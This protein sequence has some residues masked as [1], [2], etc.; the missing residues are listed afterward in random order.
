MRWPSAFVSLL[1]RFAH[2]VTEVEH[3]DMSEALCAWTP[4]YLNFGL[5]RSFDFTNPTWQE[6]L[7]AYRT[8][9]DPEEWT[10]SF[11]LAHAREYPES[12]F[13]CFSYHYE[14]EARS[15]RFHFGNRDSSGRGPFREE[16]R[17]ERLRELTSMF[18]DVRRH[19]PE[20][21]FVRGRSWMYNVLPY[22]HLFPEEYI[23]TATPVEAELQFMSLWGQ[24]LDH[25]LRVRSDRS[26]TFLQ[27][28][29]VA[30]SA[31]DLRHSFPMPV[32][33]PRCSIDHFY[34]FYDIN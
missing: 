31:A 11:Y 6:F 27:A 23:R 12:P 22:R 17:L 4:L 30:S 29:A 3:I 1:L 25:T 14:P 21:R 28:I 7:S 24:F 10:Y 13:G 5:D 15:I 8:A 34:A 19:L 26:H 18:A 16:R 9:V 32:L 33:A 20:A 2:R